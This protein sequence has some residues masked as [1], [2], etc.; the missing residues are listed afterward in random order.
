[1]SKKSGKRI[2]F[3]V[4]TPDA[5]LSAL[6]VVS[7]NGS[8]VYIGAKGVMG[9]IKV[10]LHKSGIWPLAFTSESG[11]VSSLT[12]DR[13]HTQVN[14]PN[15]FQTGWTQALAVLVPGPGNRKLFAKPPNVWDDADVTWLARPPIND[16]RV[17]G[18]YLA[19]DAT[20]D[21]QAE[22]RQDSQQIYATDLTNG[23]SLRV[24]TWL[25]GTNKAERD[26][27]NNL[28]YGKDAPKFDMT[29]EQS[30]VAVNLFHFSTEGGFYRITD[31]Q[32][33]PEH[34]NWKQQGAT[35]AQPV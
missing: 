25:D 29:G 18:V 33:G 22:V 17:F 14:R 11:Q 9:L 23:E 34:F 27:L 6:W 31:V 3:A 13:R 15:E 26:Y 24:I 30:D 1:M 2:K 28:L 21:F 8:E 5:P 12:N 4:G 20:R 16:K 7:V 10:S 35:I 19:S 32:L